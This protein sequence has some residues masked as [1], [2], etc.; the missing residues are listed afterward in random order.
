MNIL[1][2]GG[3]GYLG[4]ALTT[5]L[6]THSANV[7]VNVTW[8][9]RNA[10][11]KP[12]TPSIKVMDYQALNQTEQR[13][14]IIINLAG[15]GIADSRWT[16]KRK[17]QLYDSRLNPTQAVLDYMRRIAVKPKLFISGSAIG[18]YGAQSSNTCT[19][20]NTDALTEESSFITDD[21]AHQLCDKW[22]SLALTAT[23][24][25]VPVAIV[26]TGIVLSSNGGMI[27]KLKLPFSLGVG[28]RL[29][30]GKQVMSWISRDDWVRA[31][32]FIINYH[33]AT[34]VSLDSNAI[35]T[36]T[37]TPQVADT[38]ATQSATTHI[39][40][41]TAATAVNN[42]EFTK[43]VGSWLNRPTV[44]AQPQALLK[45]IFG[46]MATLLIDGQRVVPKR[47]LEL[48]FKFKDNTVA[49]AL[50]V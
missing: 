34:N 16:D 19:T 7:N 10:K 36:A 23:S 49:E 11:T 42:A 44:F 3:S 32:Q 48:G 30:S 46:E 29:A 9:S 45:L 1:I 41:L 17:Q 50:A 28:G 15:A 37:D 14:D 38:L 2:T 25:N 8:V 4:Q 40:N 39:Y 47:L 21:F 26:R 22:E 27:A 18:W 12:N 31:V 33:L 20:D 6:L 24:F 13:F 35:N 5:A 43:A